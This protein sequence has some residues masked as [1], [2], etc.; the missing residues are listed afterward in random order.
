MPFRDIIG[1]EQPIAAL[2]SALGQ[3]RL[4]HAYLFYGE[5]HIGKFLTAVRLAQALNC[6]EAGSIERRDSCGTCRS[7]LQIAARTHPD[8]VV[9]EP[10]RELTVPQIK[11][12]H[13]RDIE[14]QLVYRPLL[15]EKKICIINDADCLTI[16]AA[17]ALLKTLEEPPP[18]GLFLLISSR[19]MALPATIRSRCQALRFLSPAYSAVEAALV[20]QRHLP[21]TDAQFLTLCCNGRI[22]EALVQDL[23]ALR[24]EQNECLA[25]IDPSTLSSITAIISAAET[26]AKEG[27]GSRI[28]S[29][30]GRWIRDV[31]LVLVGGDPQHLLHRNHLDQLQKYAHKANLDLLLDLA[32]E[33]EQISQQATRHPN[34]QMALETILLRLREAFGLSRLSSPVTSLSSS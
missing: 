16:G 34:L 17:N 8:Y 31:L 30:L 25:L 20:R 21:P 3:G 6:E 14:H 22:G 18:Y 23:A 13:I 15:S 27:R 7:C 12:E 11:I 33:L 24:T 1:H 28:L 5:A 29:W 32:E 4:A 2:Q 10:D 19:P 9:I 26:L